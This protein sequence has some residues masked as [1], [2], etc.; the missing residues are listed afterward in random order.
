MNDLTK[1]KV[2]YPVYTADGETGK[3]TRQVDPVV[4]RYPVRIR[5]GASE[6]DFTYDGRYLDKL[7][8]SFYAEPPRLAQ[9]GTCD[10]SE[11]EKDD[12]VY[13]ENG[14]RL[15]VI[16]VD[17]KYISAGHYLRMPINGR[18]GLGRQVFFHANPHLEPT[19]P[20]AFEVPEHIAK[21]KKSVDWTE[22]PID[23]L[24][25]TTDKP[26]NKAYTIKRYFAGVS[27][28]GKPLC[29]NGGAT[30]ETTTIKYQPV[31]VRLI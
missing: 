8:I 20:K 21:R 4:N 27:L 13:L 30:S 23:T 18:D 26:D 11:Y 25:E 14:S 16:E 28:D 9:T 5:C 15:A 6:L 10:F 17:G 22:V 7:P 31:E 19:N 3:I 2:G 1:L 24:V 29:W 12:L